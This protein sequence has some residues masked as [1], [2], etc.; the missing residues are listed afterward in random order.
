[1]LWNGREIKIFR[2]KYDPSLPEVILCSKEKEKKNHGKVASGFTWMAAG[3]AIFFLPLPGARPAG[4]A[5]IMKGGSDAS[6]AI[7]GAEISTS[8]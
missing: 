7:M 8:F 4:L 3:F 2:G 1:M 5:M 6:G